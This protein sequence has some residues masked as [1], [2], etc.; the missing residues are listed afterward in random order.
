MTYHSLR[1]KIELVGRSSCFILSCLN[2]TNQAT[3]A[4]STSTESVIRLVVGLSSLAMSKK[5][6]MSKF[7]L[8]AKVIWV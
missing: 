2:R 1:D 6:E 8:E 3:F 4:G 7:S 5:E